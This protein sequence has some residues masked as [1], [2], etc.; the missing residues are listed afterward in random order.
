MLTLI[1][2]KAI[3]AVSIRILS[4]QDDLFFQ[5]KTICFLA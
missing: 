4:R 3:A 5:D 2:V 1:R